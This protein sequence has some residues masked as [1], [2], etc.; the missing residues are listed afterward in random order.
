MGAKSKVTR[1]VEA[2]P[3]KLA[4]LLELNIGKILHRL[5]KSILTSKLHQKDKAEILR[6]LIFASTVIIII[7]LFVLN[8]F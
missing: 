4:Q 1:I 3:A 2:T 6:L 7:A 5:W 8:R